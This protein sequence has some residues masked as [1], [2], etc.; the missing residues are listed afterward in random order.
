MTKRAE[1]KRVTLKVCRSRTERH[2]LME[3]VAGEQVPR[4]LGG[5]LFLNPDKAEFYRAVAKEIAARA[6]RG[7]RI[8][9]YDWPDL[10]PSRFE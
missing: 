2:T 9:Y 6:G 1:P 3:Y 5:A 7:E 10:W 4:D 8:I